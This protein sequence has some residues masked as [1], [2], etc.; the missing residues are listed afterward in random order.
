MRIGFRNDM[1]RIETY[2]TI[3]YVQQYTRRETWCLQ[4]FQIT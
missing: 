3:N 1:A 2:P 4:G